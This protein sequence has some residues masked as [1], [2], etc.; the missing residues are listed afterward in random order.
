MIDGH[1][2][3]ELTRQ[4]NAIDSLQTLTDT[5]ERTVR[6]IT[7]ETASSGL[8]DRYRSARPSPTEEDLGERE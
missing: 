5:L 3:V 6:T 2:T 8:I 4:L 7:S 1:E